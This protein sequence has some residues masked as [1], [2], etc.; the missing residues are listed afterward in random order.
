MCNLLTTVLCLSGDTSV[1]SDQW[2]KIPFVSVF[3]SESLGDHLRSY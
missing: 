2:V 3:Q 1:V